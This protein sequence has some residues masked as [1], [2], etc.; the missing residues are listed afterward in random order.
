MFKPS[1]CRPHHKLKAAAGATAGNTSKVPFKVPEDMPTLLLA[2]KML[3]ISAYRRFVA[4]L[5]LLAI[6]TFADQRFNVKEANDGAKMAYEAVTRAAFGKDDER[7]HDLLT[8]FVSDKVAERMISAAGLNLA[9]SVTVHHIMHTEII[10]ARM[11]RDVEATDGKGR[12]FP[13]RMF[14]DVRFLTCE[15]V[16]NSGALPARPLALAPARR[17][18]FGRSLPPA[19]QQCPPRAAVCAS[20]AL[21]LTLA[22]AGP[23]RSHGDRG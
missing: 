13:T 16:Y 9:S 12:P 11:T 5:Q 14:F 8:E 19:V 15:S 2:H 6:R 20:L 4:G 21:V 1:F 10:A 23:A 3:G 7:D 18:R 17:L 22:H